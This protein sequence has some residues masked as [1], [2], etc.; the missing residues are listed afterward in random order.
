MKNISILFILCLLSITSCVDTT[1][2]RLIVGKWQGTQWL[3]NGTASTNNAAATF[4]NF[5]TAGNYQFVYDGTTQKGTYKVDHNQLFTKANGAQEIMVLI[6]KLTAD[7]LVFDMNRSGQS[8][9]L[10]LVKSK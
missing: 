3:V 5:D 6:T 2:N 1:N 4:F 7:S 8:E 9:T 10:Y